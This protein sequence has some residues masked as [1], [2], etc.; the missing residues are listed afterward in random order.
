MAR[1][2]VATSGVGRQPWTAAAARDA[3]AAASTIAAAAAA[4][5]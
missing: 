5:S 2:E 1:R 4:F 3:R